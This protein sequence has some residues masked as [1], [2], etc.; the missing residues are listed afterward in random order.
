[1]LVLPLKFA[2]QGVTNTF[3][4]TLEDVTDAEAP[5]TGTA[6]VAA[7]IWV[8]VDGAAPANATNAMTALG[9]GMYLWVAVAA[10]LAGART[11]VS[12]YD[13][14]GSATFKPVFMEVVTR[15]TLST[16]TIDATAVGGNTDAVT[17]TAV[18]TGKALN[19]SGA[20][21][22]Y[23]HNLF[24]QSEVAEP[25]TAPADIAT[26]KE[27]FQFL[28]RRWRNKHTASSTE[29]KVYKDDATAVLSTQALTNS[30]SLQSVGE[31]T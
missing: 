4:F 24:D 31:T 13:A 19:V 3:L 9:N 21:S 12:V 15:L 29:L 18:G 28:K 2:K 25:S 27:I 23:N 26:F 7:D 6:P 22:S 5:Y 11:Y 1:M 16:L 8:S 20:T 10:E 30:G 17:L 14:T